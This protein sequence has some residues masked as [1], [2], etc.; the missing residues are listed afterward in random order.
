M[1]S[2]AKLKKDLIFKMV[3]QLT[4]KLNGRSKR[5]LLVFVGNIA[6][7]LFGV[8]TAEGDVRILASHI[9]AL[10]KQNNKSVGALK[11]YGGN[12]ASFSTQTD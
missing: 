8:A 12:F 9:Y 11:Q 6:S 2:Q 5:A 7:N 3:P 4:T 1:T 10:T